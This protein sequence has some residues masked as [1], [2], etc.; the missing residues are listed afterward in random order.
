LGELVV[1]VDDADGVTGSAGNSDSELG[2]RGALDG[3]GGGAAVCPGWRFFREGFF[4]AGARYVAE[5]ET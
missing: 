5:R 4:C 3:P 2:A 1:K